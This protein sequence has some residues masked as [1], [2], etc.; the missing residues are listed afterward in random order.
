MRVTIKPVFAAWLA[1]AVL[2]LEFGSCQ[3]AGAS[4]DADLVCGARLGL[5][6]RAEARRVA[7]ELAAAALAELTAQRLAAELETARARAAER[8]P[9][10]A[11]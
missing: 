3:A 5:D 7:T 4:P 10:P 8:P 11:Q 2:A 6:V 9:S 1:G